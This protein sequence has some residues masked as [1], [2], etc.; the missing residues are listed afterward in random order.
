MENNNNYNTAQPAENSSFNLKRIIGLF[1]NKWYWFL[2]SVVLCC[3]IG[4]YKIVSTT[5]EYTRTATLIIKESAMRRASSSDVEALLSNAGQI[6][7]KLANELV[8]FQAPSIMTEA[9]SRLGLTVDYAF[10]GRFRD[11]VIYGPAVPV[12]VDFSKVP[13]NVFVKF[14]LTPVNEDSCTISNLN[15]V[16]KK[17]KFKQKKNI[18]VVYGQ[19]V[20]LPFGTIVV[21]RNPYHY[22][23]N[24]WTKT[25]KVT[26][27]SL[28][29]TSR[30]YQKRFSASSADSKQRL[31]DVINLSMTDYSTQRADDLMNMIITVYNEKWVV[32]NNQMAKS[33]SNFIAER[34]A[35]I[36]SELGK[37][38][39][40]IS[41]YKSQNKMPSVDAASTM[42]MNQTTDIARQIRELENELSVTK[43]MRN[44]MSDTISEEGLIPLPAGISNTALVSQ[45]TEYNKLL[46]NRNNL[47]SV[48]SEKNPL[49]LDLDA[50]L[51]AMRAAIIASIDS[52]VLSLEEQVAFALNQQSQTEDQIAKNP[53]QAKDLLVYER[54]QKVQENLYLYLL[55]KREENELSQAFSAYNTRV[56]NPP[57]GSPAPVSPQSSKILMIAFLL[58]LIIPA[59]V[60]YLLD[61]TDTKVRTKKDL[62]CLKP[63]FLGEIPLDNKEV[64]NRTKLQKLIKKQSNEANK[65]KLVVEQGNRNMINEAFRIVRTNLEF[66]TRGQKGNVIIA[67]SFNP[68]S[69]KSFVCINLAQAFA[70]KDKK[71]LLIDGDFRRLSTSKFFNFGKKGFADYLSIGTGDIHDYIY[72]AG[73][74]KTFDVLP[75]GT[76][77][78]NPNELVGSELFSETVN[79]LKKEYDYVFI[80]SAPIDIVADTQII[81]TLADRTLFVVRA[82][83]LEKDL[84]PEINVMYDEK[85]FN[86]MSILLNGSIVG[87]KSYGSYTTYGYGYG[88][89]HS[90]RYYK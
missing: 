26:K 55:Q 86:G 14:E 27:R 74:G 53:S 84:L 6:P 90:D 81:A 58:G 45:V 25:A 65:Q 83:L 89:K 30:M 50:R 82:G 22:S 29:S 23:E 36:E 32:D 17:D 47:L 3:F 28:S 40:N 10:K 44:Y 5:P 60:I 70:L 35:A 9:V 15:Y 13:D 56:V 77:A 63:G 59:G 34:L 78:P 7:S 79:A 20:E 87:N 12:S 88:S 71:V 11:N 85:R 69:G 33:T 52:Q 24:E 19:P 46:L 51:A 18:K 39:E 73:N 48:S 68:G 2:I 54:L 41:R 64:T 42:Y 80:D 75:V 16:I 21:E 4:A 8:V 31:S 76:L 61:V 1:L 38:D 72:K 43:Y 62:E 37:V 57:F 49:V 66:I 67:T